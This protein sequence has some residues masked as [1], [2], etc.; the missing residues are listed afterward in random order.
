MMG[1]TAKYL[2]LRLEIANLHC[3]ESNLYRRLGLS[4][5]TV[6]HWFKGTIFKFKGYI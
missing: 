5:Q 6:W 3:W 4:V 2:K 1:L